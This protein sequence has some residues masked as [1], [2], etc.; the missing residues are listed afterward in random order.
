MDSYS[1][2]CGLHG[3]IA[4][5]EQH[6]F[7][8]TTVELTVNEIAI[9]LEALLVGELGA[10]D[11][12]AAASVICGALNKRLNETSVL[13]TPIEDGSIRRTHLNADERKL[14]CSL[15]GLNFAK[16]QD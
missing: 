14:Y 16:K 8:S 2:K 1:E 5:F 6:K 10:E 7:S 3:P 9:Q 4:A 12:Y 13:H 11:W 15:L